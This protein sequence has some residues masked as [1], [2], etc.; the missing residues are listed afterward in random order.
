[1]NKTRVYIVNWRNY[2]SGDAVF[3][4]V[5]FTKEAAVAWVA[6]ARHPEDYEIETYEETENGHSKEIFIG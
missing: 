4:G 3:R 1:M 6:E 2:Y 5:F